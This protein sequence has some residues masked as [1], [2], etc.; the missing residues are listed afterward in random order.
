MLLVISVYDVVCYLSQ[1]A[2]HLLSEKEKNDLAQLVSTMVAYSITHRSM[3]SNT[4]PSNLGHEAADASVLSF[5]P[6]IVDFISF[7]V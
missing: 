6:P 7:K 3:K 1:V 5:D 4:Q 2:S